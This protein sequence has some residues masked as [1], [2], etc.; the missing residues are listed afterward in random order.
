MF[1]ARFKALGYSHVVSWPIFE[2]RGGGCIMY[3]M[4]HASDHPEAPQLMARAY[5]HALQRREPQQR[6][7]DDLLTL[8][9]PVHSATGTEG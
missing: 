2:R 1:E 7:I 5:N 3:Y 4:I 6:T 8:I 9:P